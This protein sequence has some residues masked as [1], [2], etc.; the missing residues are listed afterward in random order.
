M[1]TAKSYEDFSLLNENLFPSNQIVN[2]L[3]GDRMTILCSTSDTNGEYLK[4]QFD[5]PPG[6]KGSPLHYH[7]SMH[8]T[9]EVITGLAHLKAY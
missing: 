3:T 2:T 6:A 7:V 8:E 4:V 1:T 5:L 9:F